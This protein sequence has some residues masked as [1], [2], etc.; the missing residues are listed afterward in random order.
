MAKI[1]VRIG[2][3]IAGIEI[4]ELIP[5]QGGIGKTAFVLIHSRTQ[6]V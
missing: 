3:L 5:I 6:T 2:M 1:I 4:S